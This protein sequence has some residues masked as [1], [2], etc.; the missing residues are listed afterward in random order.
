MSFTALARCTINS[1]VTPLIPVGSLLHFSSSLPV[2]SSSKCAKCKAGAFGAGWFLQREET[3]S[4]WFWGVI[5]HLSPWALGQLHR[6]FLLRL[7]LSNKSKSCP[8]VPPSGRLPLLSGIWK[9]C[10]RSSLSST[11]LIN[12]GESSQ[13]KKQP[14]L[15]D[16]LRGRHPI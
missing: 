4:S 10:H 7:P 14:E 2:P 5:S 12:P 1:L 9:A 15:G 8:A 13:G 16:V 11:P 6:I 3:G